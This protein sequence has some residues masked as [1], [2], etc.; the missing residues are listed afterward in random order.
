M[1][2]ARTASVVTCGFT[3][4]EL[5]CELVLWRAET[6]LGFDVSL[7]A[8][9]L[10]PSIIDVDATVVPDLISGLSRSALELAREGLS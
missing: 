2:A 5:A 10:T 1:A 6:R 7:S 3:M 8:C 4:L 9:K